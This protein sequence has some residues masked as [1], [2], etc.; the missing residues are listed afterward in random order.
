MFTVLFWFFVISL[1]MEG[2]CLFFVGYDTFWEEMKH[3]LVVG[4][5]LIFVTYLKH[6]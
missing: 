3:I 4:F 6:L 1:V 2:V 5:I